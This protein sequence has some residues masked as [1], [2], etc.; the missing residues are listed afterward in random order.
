[1]DSISSGARL[2]GCRVLRTADE[3]FTAARRSIRHARG[4]IR[5]GNGNAV[6]GGI[7]VIQLVRRARE[8]TLLGLQN[9]FRFPESSDERNTDKVG[10]GF[11]R[12]SNLDVRVCRVHV[13]FEVRISLRIAGK[14]LGCRHPFGFSTD[15]E[16]LDQ[17]AIQPDVDLVRLPH[18][19]EVQI[20][21]AFQ[22]HFDLIFAVEPEVITD[23]ST[24]LGTERKI[25][26]W[27]GHPDS[28]LS[29]YGTRRQPE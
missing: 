7:A 22:E 8:T 20:Q 25:I 15:F 23:R 21:L 2:F 16:S 1:M 13:L 10:A 19:N 11:H 3:N 14:A 26:A 9:A 27:S 17:C 18:A 29:G 4:A 28:M 5:P 6:D 24:A 12:Q